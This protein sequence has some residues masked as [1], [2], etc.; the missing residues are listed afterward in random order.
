MTSVVT[1]G[2]AKGYENTRREALI[3]TLEKGG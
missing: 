2:R 1:G 3:L